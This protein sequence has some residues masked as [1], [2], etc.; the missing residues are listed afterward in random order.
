MYRRRTPKKNYASPDWLS[1]HCGLSQNLFLPCNTKFLIIPVHPNNCQLCIPTII[2]VNV[3]CLTLAISYFI[4]LLQPLF[5]L[6]LFEKVYREGKRLAESI[7]SQNCWDAQFVCK[8]CKSTSSVLKEC[9]LTYFLI[10]FF[11]F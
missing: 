7:C 8:K 10:T 11:S 4:L 3:C 2:K 9:L 6:C 5:V 1:A